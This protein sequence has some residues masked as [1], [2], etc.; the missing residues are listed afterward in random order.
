MDYTPATI[1]CIIAAADY[2]KVPANVMLAIISVEGGKNG[3]A[4]RNKNGTYDLGHMQINTATYKAEIAKY[5]I[6]IN[7]IRYNGC[8]NVEVA[9]FLLAKRIS[10]NPKSD[11]WVRVAGYHSKTPFYNTIYK[12]KIIPLAH[13]WAEW[14]NKSYATT[15]TIYK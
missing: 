4:V 8:K 14:L 5:G 12:Q 9:A 2:Q 10:E 11:Y 13:I 15:K 6:N 3:Q 1:E 7:E